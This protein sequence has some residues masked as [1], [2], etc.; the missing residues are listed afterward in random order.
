MKNKKSISKYISKNRIWL[1]YKKMSEESSS[2]F[3][4]TYKYLLK[5]YKLTRD[6]VMF[7]YLLGQDLPTAWNSLLANSLLSRK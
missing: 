5:T 6:T 7:V 2:L 3:G 4:K 1:K